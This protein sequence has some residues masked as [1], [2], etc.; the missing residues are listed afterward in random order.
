VLPALIPPDL[1]VLVQFD[2]PLID[3]WQYGQ[4]HHIA[5]IA[6]HTLGDI[7][8]GSILRI[9][10]PR[11]MTVL[12]SL[13]GQVFG[14]Y[15]AKVGNLL[16]GRLEGTRIP[17]MS[18]SSTTWLVSREPT[19]TPLSS[20]RPPVIPAFSGRRRAVSTSCVLSRGHSDRNARVRRRPF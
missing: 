5:Q 9:A 19:K 1:R 16:S 10:N 6:F 11:P 4:I 14:A 2:D 17:E 18:M 12:G 13:S 15:S 7:E 3:L 20:S 8:A